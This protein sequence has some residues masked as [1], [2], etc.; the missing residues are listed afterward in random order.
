MPKAPTFRKGREKPDEAVLE[1]APSAQVSGEN[2]EG[3]R[4]QKLRLGSD[5]PTPN[6]AGGPGR[7]RQ[8]RARLPEQL[9]LYEE[10]SSAADGHPQQARPSRRT[11]A[12]VISCPLCRSKMRVVTIAL[13]V[14]CPSCQA[15]VDV[16]EVAPA[17]LLGVKPPLSRLPSSTPAPVE[18][19]LHAAVP[20]LPAA[21]AS[22]FVG[23]VPTTEE[24]STAKTPTRRRHG[25]PPVWITLGV[26]VLLGVMG[27]TYW[28]IYPKKGQIV[29]E[30]A[31]P[32][33]TLPTA[34]SPVLAMVPQEAPSRLVIGLPELGNKPP[35]DEPATPPVAAPP[36]ATP[37]AE[38][39]APVPEAGV[40]QA[41][42]PANI[43]AAPADDVF[44][45]RFDSKL[46]A[47][48]PSG[49]RALDAPL[50]AV[51][52]GRKIRIKI[53]GCA[54]HGGIPAGQDCAALTR[55]LKSILAHRGVDHP[56]GLIASVDPPMIMF[57]W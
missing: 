55:S 12:L 5:R 51:S 32:L 43:R 48:T 6:N 11:S 13:N 20:S 18:T 37:V 31:T 14:E 50:R 7:Y 24:A 36:V 4:I 21:L 35:R 45:V 40:P 25:A 3:I 47:L 22:C 17:S 46:P 49:L 44:V 1:A 38:T 39:P 42:V 26:A 53:G 10:P 2:R 41:F 34:A 33:E 56:A 19:R 27:V 54:T 57:P 15:I 16:L 29:P 23:T 8:S 9:D 28:P 52:K 30:I